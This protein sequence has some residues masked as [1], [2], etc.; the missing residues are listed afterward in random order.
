MD[1]LLSARSGRDDS[2]AFKSYHHS[3]LSSAAAAA[4]SIPTYQT[5]LVWGGGI[6][7]VDTKRR[8]APIDPTPTHPHLSLSSLDRFLPSSSLAHL[9]QSRYITEIDKSMPP[10]PP[11]QSSSFFA[12]SSTAK[13]TQKLVN[14]NTPQHSGSVSDNNTTSLSAAA[15]A[16]SRELTESLSLVGI[17]EEG[18]GG[19]YDKD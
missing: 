3:T 4:S 13:N 10:Q 9:S 12:T 7:P 16:L 1:I 11:M 2:D 6:G 18:G 5:P 19:G 15:A 8:F 17:G 14:N